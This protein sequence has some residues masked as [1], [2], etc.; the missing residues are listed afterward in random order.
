ML[1]VFWVPFLGVPWFEPGGFLGFLWGSFQKKAKEA[2]KIKE[3]YFHWSPITYSLYNTSLA[4]AYFRRLEDWKQNTTIIPKMNAFLGF[5][6]IT[7]H[8]TQCKQSFSEGL[9]NES[10]KRSW[11][12]PK[13]R[14]L[15][16]KRH[17]RQKGKK[18]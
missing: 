2:K 17:Q 3:C 10:L 12:T 11:E 16:K 4:F 18:V 5:Q 15:E 1:S 7:P 8:K 14:R 13:R 9:K 6:T